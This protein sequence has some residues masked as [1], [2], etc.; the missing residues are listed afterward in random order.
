MRSLGGLT[1]AWVAAALYL[2]VFL[3]DAWAYLDPGTGSYIFQML[4]ASIVGG[5][6]ALKMYWRRLKAWVRRKLG[7]KDD[8]GSQKD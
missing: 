6:F 1:V 7:K 2:G 8:D 4:I 5:L 3:S